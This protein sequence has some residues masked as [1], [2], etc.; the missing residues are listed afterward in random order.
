MRKPLELCRRDGGEEGEAVEC[1][2]WNATGGLMSLVR[3]AVQRVEKWQTRSVTQDSSTR[4]L[5]NLVPPPANGGA[6]RS[7]LGT[8]PECPL[9]GGNLTPEHAHFKCRGCGWRDSCC[10]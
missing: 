1:Q 8:F 2:T 5:E 4:P 3:V 7:N 10:D 6:C 9:C